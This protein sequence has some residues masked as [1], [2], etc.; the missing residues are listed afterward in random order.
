[1]KNLLRLLTIAALTATF[2][3]PAFA[4]EASAQ[5]NEARAA[6]YQRFIDDHRS[7]DPTKQKAAYDTG[8]EYLTKYASLADA[9][10]AAIVKYVQNWV[11]KYEKAA[12][13]YEL[14]KCFDD[15]L[16]NKDWPRSFECG[17]KILA[18]E[19]E[20]APVTLTLANV[21]Y[22]NA[23][24]GRAVN[25]A[26]LP[27]SLR[28]MRRAIELIEAGKV[29]PD[30]LRP[31]TSKEEATG[32]YHLG[33]SYGQLDAQPEE[34]AKSLIKLAQ[35]NSVSAKN[36]ATYSSL[37]F[38]Y[39]REYKK[40]ATEYQQKFP[41][42]TEVTPELKPEYERLQGQLDRIADRIIDAYSRAVALSTK[43]EQ[44]AG[45][46]DAMTELTRIYK[47]RHNGSDAGLKEMM[48]GVL[49]KPLPIPGQE[50]AP[51]PTT[52]SA[53]PG[54]NPQTSQ[55]GAPAGGAAKPA[56]NAAKPA[57]ATPQSAKPNT[58]PASPKPPSQK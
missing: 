40:A 48:A 49:A 20:N 5:D 23:T 25:K 34:A 44:Q 52:T 55:T 24:A 8:K 3:L 47:S 12:A 18:N 21:G 15:A 22:A 6:L 13:D 42:G 54:A 27:D 41:E 31:F 19:P 57:A 33:L 46:N 36:P 53:T 14:K 45:K 58:A 2:A 29:T 32:H 7:S 10:N 26:I 51:A 39:T 28:M 1:M 17:N 35:T 43:P 37:A 11:S 30:Q 16:R 50:P 38:F 9:D 56:A 4:Q